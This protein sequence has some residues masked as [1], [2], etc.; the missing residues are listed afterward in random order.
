[1]PDLGECMLLN[2]YIFTICILYVRP[3][4]EILGVTRYWDIY[5]QFCENLSLSELEESDW[6]A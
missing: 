4:S 5:C 3:H 2:A 1:M 6:Q